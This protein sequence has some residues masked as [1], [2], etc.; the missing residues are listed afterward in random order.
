MFPQSFVQTHIKENIKVLRHCEGNPVVSG[1]FHSQRANNADNVSIW[2]RRHG[3][4]KNEQNAHLQYTQC[5]D[6]YLL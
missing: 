6:K 1:G 3:I 4:A 2:W 5:D